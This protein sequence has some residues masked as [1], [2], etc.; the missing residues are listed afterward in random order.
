MS[1]EIVCGSCFPDEV[2]PGSAVTCG[3]CC[4]T[5]RCGSALCHVIN[6]LLVLSPR[7]MCSQF[8]HKY[9]P[10]KHCT[11]VPSSTALIALHRLVHNRI[12]SPSNITDLL[13]TSRGRL[14]KLAG[15]VFGD[16]VLLSLVRAWAANNVLFRTMCSVQSAVPVE[17]R[18]RAMRTVRS[19]SCGAKFPRSP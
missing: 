17:W 9:A 8:S 1:L 12:C 18:C 10:A 6:H 11:A 15:R 16:T 14:V 3:P 19:R 4:P 13:Q 7:T 2:I 5:L